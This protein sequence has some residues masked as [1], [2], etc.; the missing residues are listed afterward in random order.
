MMFSAGTHVQSTGK[1][2]P[3][4]A[5]QQYEVVTDRAVESSAAVWTLD[6]ITL[7]HTD[8]TSLW[9]EEERGGCGLVRN[10][11]PPHHL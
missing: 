10:L 6:D 7:P 8:N 1:K 4:W 2:L 3:E 5:F 11:R 9:E